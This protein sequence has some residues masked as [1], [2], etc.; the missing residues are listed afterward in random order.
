MLCN[1]AEFQVASKDLATLWGVKKRLQRGRKFLL[2]VKIFC[3]DILY[4]VP[5][6]SV[7][8]LDG[9]EIA[10]LLKLETGSVETNRVTRI[11]ARM[12]R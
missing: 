9:V 3:E 8:R 11:L 10:D 1:E 2:L 4:A 6:V 7:T 12:E 5:E